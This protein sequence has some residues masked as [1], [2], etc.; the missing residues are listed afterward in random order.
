MLFQLKSEP[1]LWLLWAWCPTFPIGKLEQCL[2]ALSWFSPCWGGTGL[3]HKEPDAIH[4]HQIFL[5]RREL[6][7]VGCARGRTD[8]MNQ[9]HYH[10]LHQ[11][12]LRQDHHHLLQP[13]KQEGLWGGEEQLS[14]TRKSS[15]TASICHEENPQDDQLLDGRVYWCVLTF[16]HLV[17]QLTNKHTSYDIKTDLS[18]HSNDVISV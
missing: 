1:I 5:K 10:G 13:P 4:Y 7:Y 18:F 12:L 8:Q 9:E 14:F 2:K 17:L 15:N 6:W 3:R 16:N 11:H